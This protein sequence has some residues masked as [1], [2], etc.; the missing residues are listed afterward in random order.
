MNVGAGTRYI[1][2][3]SGRASSIRRYER[4]LQELLQLNMAYLPISP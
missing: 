4:L 3:T 2:S 1:I